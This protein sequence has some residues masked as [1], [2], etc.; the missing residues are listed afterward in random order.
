MF[1]GHCCFPCYEVCKWDSLFTLESKSEVCAEA[2]PS[3]RWAE[4][5]KLDF[6]TS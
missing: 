1:C 2:I 5:G 4:A 3:T 6:K